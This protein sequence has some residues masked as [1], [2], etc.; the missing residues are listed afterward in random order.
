MLRVLFDPDGFFKENRD[1][2]LAV[3]LAVIVVSCVVSGLGVYMNLDLIRGEFLK[4]VSLYIPQEK[5]LK[6]F[7]SFKYLIVVNACVSAVLGWVV[8]SA[9]VHMISSLLGGYGGF[10]R[11]LKVMSFGYLPKIILFPLNQAVIRLSGSLLN[12]ATVIMG[13]ASTA[14]EIYIMTFGVK[15]ARDIRTDKAFLSVFLSVIVVMLIGILGKIFSR[16]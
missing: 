1:P 13:I 14:W 15:N 6:L 12:P 16:V 4:S 8:L 11:T 3:A 9:L 7:E 5:A 10:V 2:S